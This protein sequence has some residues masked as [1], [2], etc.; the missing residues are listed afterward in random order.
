MSK[1]WCKNCGWEGNE[2]EVDKDVVDTCMGSDEIE[3]CPKCSRVVYESVH[4]DRK[5]D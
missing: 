5:N 3:L 1:Y 2:E 4:N